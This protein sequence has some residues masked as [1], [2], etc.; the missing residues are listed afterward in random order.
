MPDSSADSGS[1]ISSSKIKIQE[2]SRLADGDL[3]I[4]FSDETTVLFHAKFLYDV[5]NHDGNVQIV[6]PFKK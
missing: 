5:R 2:A 4:T 6:D 1:K 3:L